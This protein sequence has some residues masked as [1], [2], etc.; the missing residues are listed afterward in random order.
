MYIVSRY[1]DDAGKWTMVAC[2]DWRSDAQ[3]I[4]KQL[5]ERNPGADFR[6]R[7]I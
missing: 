5:E 2:C 6:Y 1:N 4:K 7:K 3:A